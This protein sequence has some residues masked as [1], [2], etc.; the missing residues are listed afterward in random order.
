MASRDASD[1]TLRNDYRTRF[2]NY[3]A[4]KQDTTAVVIN[5][6]GGSDGANEA[7]E[8]TY[9]KIGS[10]LVPIEELLAV[11]PP[12]IPPSI[13]KVSTLYY[14]PLVNPQS[15]VVTPNGI[16]MTDGTSLYSLPSG[17]VIPSPDSIR[18]LAVD[19]SGNLYAASSSNIYAYTNG[20]SNMNI[21]GLTNILN[22][23]VST[24]FY[25]VQQGESFIYRAESNGPASV[26]AG[27]TPGI[28]DGSPGELTTPQGLTLD[29]SGQYLYIA[30]SGISLI[31]KMSTSSPY[32]LSTIAGQAIVYPG[33]FPTDNAGNRDG[34]GIQG[35]N[36]LY[37]PQGITGSNVFY[38]AD[39]ANNNIRRLT[40]DGNLSTLSG[41]PGV[42]P[43]YSFAP[44]GYTDSSLAKSVWNSPSSI[45]L[46]GSLLYVSEPLN[47]AVRVILLD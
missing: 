37:F 34:N 6:V 24:V 11:V 39:T 42:D 36:L 35:E 10:T 45:F 7:S 4:R 28:A 29:S 8:N 43:I 26:V 12:I 32:T 22:F 23:A 20:F 30:D 18:A 21:T 41:E 14:N 46:Y 47:H 38:I 3:T 13:I 19:P 9:L 2:I 17:S 16:F 31:R 1:V 27:S 44:A 33:G 40:S 5:I 15:T 25:I